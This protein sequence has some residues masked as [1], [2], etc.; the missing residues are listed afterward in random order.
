[1]TLTHLLEI[2]AALRNFKVLPPITEFEEINVSA[3]L[4][5]NA[6][7][8][9]PKVARPSRLDDLLGRRTALKVMEE[10][11]LAQA[12]SFLLLLCKCCTFG[13][14]GDN[15]SIFLYPLFQA[16]EP[17]KDSPEPD[18]EDGEGSDAETDAAFE[19][20]LKGNSKL[21]D[22]GGHMSAAVLRQVSA[23]KA[24]HSQLNSLGKG[25]SC[26]SQD[27]RSQ[28]A[29]EFQIIKKCITHFLLMILQLTAFFPFNRPSEQ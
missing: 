17:G 11:R 5:S 20:M 2:S 16:K 7:L 26:Y 3:A 10:R 24:K 14:G 23:L 13:F 25:L 1:M 27:C 8:H 9:Y 22:R 28:A 6:R 19:G 4:S 21:K 15:F 12:V 18:V 29:S